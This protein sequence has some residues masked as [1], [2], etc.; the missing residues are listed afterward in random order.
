[1]TD[2]GFCV[3]NKWDK[4]YCLNYATQK[5]NINL[6]KLNA[7]KSSW[8]NNL[9]V[10]SSAENKSKE[11]RTQPGLRTTETYRNLHVS[12]FSPDNAEHGPPRM[13]LY[14]DFHGII[15]H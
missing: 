2:T 12:V 4:K 10:R 1:L 5:E 6:L 8:D 7:N 3:R 14:R 15:L 11:L 9:Q 13:T